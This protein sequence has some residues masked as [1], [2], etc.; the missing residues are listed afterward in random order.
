MRTIERC[1]M[2]QI[3]IKSIEVNPCVFPVQRSTQL[4][5]AF[6]S[7][8][9]VAKNLRHQII[10]QNAIGGSQR[11]FSPKGARSKNDTDWLFLHEIG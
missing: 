11:I 2:C 7:I 6:L 8:E 10:R 9:N 1:Y 5:D 4:L 3:D